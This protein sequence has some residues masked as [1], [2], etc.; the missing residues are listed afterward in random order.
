MSLITSNLREIS[1]I[2]MKDFL[3]KEMRKFVNDSDD[4][5]VEMFKYPAYSTSGYGYKR[6]DREGVR[7][8]VV[9][10]PPEF[11]EQVTTDRGTR[12]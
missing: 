7:P 1:G 6:N 5:P 10:K 4:F 2:I 3:A 12:S 11:N 9:E 8:L